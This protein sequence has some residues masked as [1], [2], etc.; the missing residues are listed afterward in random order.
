MSAIVLG[1]FGLE[2]S[3]WSSNCCCCCCDCCITTGCTVVT[4]SSFFAVT[5]DIAFRFRLI[6]GVVCFI[7]CCCLGSFGCLTGAFFFVRAAAVDAGAVAAVATVATFFVSSMFCMTTF[8]RFRSKV[9][10]TRH[11]CKSTLVVE[12]T[13]LSIGCESSRFRL[14]QSRLAMDD[15]STSRVFRCS[16]TIFSIKNFLHNW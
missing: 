12:S 3:T 7:C 11:A 9:G 8:I 15:V 4:T 6:A 16:L 13:M 1:F 14:E 10:S 5:A 2:F